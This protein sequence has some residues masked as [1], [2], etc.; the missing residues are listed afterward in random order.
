MKLELAER[1]TRKELEDM[2]KKFDTASEDLQQR[3]D[4]LK[5]AQQTVA[6]LRE[7]FKAANTDI[8]AR[9][10]DL[11]RCRD[12]QG[13]TRQELETLQGE[14][15]TANTNL[16]SCK[17]KLS[18]VEPQLEQCR[19]SLGETQKKL[20]E[21]AD[22]HREIKKSLDTDRDKL[23][24]R[25]RK[26]EEQHAEVIRQLSDAKE[27]QNEKQR[28]V[29]QLREEFDQQRKELDSKTSELRDTQNKLHE[30]EE[31]VLARPSADVHNKVQESLDAVTLRC[32]ELAGKLERAEVGARGRPTEVEHKTLQIQVADWKAELDERPTHAEYQT[33]KMSLESAETWSKYWE[34]KCTEILARQPSPAEERPWEKEVLQKE[35]DTQKKL[36][37]QR[38]VSLVKTRDDRTQ[39]A[40]QVAR[41]H[42]EAIRTSTESQQLD[43]ERCQE[44]ATLRNILNASQNLAQ[45]RKD[46]L[47]KCKAE[48]AQFSKRIQTLEN[49]AEALR[50]AKQTAKDELRD[51][52]VQHAN[53]LAALREE[54][55]AKLRDAKSATEGVET[56]RIAEI[57]RVAN[58]Q[59]ELEIE[60][61]K[62]QA[63]ADAAEATDRRIESVEST[64]LEEKT[65][66]KTL[67]DA[68]IKRA[69]GL[70]KDVEKAN[71]KVEELEGRVQTVTQA[72][73]GEK[74]DAKKQLTA[75]TERA[76]GLER[77]LN[78]ERQKIESL[79]KQ[80]RDETDAA[81][82]ANEKIEALNTATRA[83]NENAKKQLDTEIGR[84]TSLRQ[85][86]EEAKQ[87]VIAAN[88]KI[89]T[90]ESTARD[91]KA[92][93]KTV[94]DTEIKRVADLK[95]EL[96]KTRQKVND[97]RQQ[98][99]TGEAATQPANNS[100]ESVRAGTQQRET[101][102]NAPNG[103][104]GYEGTGMPLWQQRYMETRR[105][106][107]SKEEL[108]KTRQK[109]SELEEQLA[110]SRK[111]VENLNTLF[112]QLTE[113]VSLTEELY[114]SCVWA[115]EGERD[116]AK[117]DYAGLQRQHNQQGHDY[118]C[119]KVVHADTVA[120]LQAKMREVELAAAQH[121]ADQK[122][123]EMYKQ[124]RSDVLQFLYRS[125][126]L[127][128]DAFADDEA[129]SV[130]EITERRLRD[131]KDAKDRID[132]VHT[133]ISDR[134]DVAC[135]RLERFDLTMSER[136]ETA[137]SLISTRNRQISELKKL[138]ATQESAH[139]TALQERKQLALALRD[140]SARYNE[141]VQFVERMS[142]K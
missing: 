7:K 19:N 45:S 16:E 91:E 47:T 33:V 88:E 92:N 15:K 31:E 27:R 62:V 20:R 83:D 140:T 137:R 12:D 134:L 116:E 60:Q 57:E 68:E 76:A 101:R 4:D 120:D 106:F 79:E 73:L 44:V 11:Q 90:V 14:F 48:A 77:E 117:V 105:S 8:E 5:K 52:K 37:E 58:L 129:S 131:C 94:L 110:D 42:D 46:E 41:M 35:I 85:E 61:Q 49:E 1:P 3:R 80:V 21:S 126:M 125:V 18:D 69:A 82:T 97:L 127:R 108:E 111:D 71:E 9:N 112:R 87:Q 64:A 128:P 89:S 78:T 17:G 139:R 54:H 23:A 40:S 10:K 70:E 115:I 59:R 102:S 38:N 99:Q 104:V 28:D 81:R 29:D 86:L 124:A 25:L 53:Q 55:E 22:A 96:E 122:E 56:L 34:A 121:D 114:K 138:V 6:D 75:E 51:A 2:Q 43:D 36:V 72:S 123:I 26:T 132:S 130:L 30:K 113:S 95:K 13:K 109:V 107:G 39:L 142:L 84:V 50:V 24:T 136:L 65:K 133:A 74:N 103:R 141:L 66:A 98:P 118:G 63:A 93:A 119:L 32:K 67:L 100:L 135:V